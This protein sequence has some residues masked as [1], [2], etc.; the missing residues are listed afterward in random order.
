M[1]TLTKAMHS[2]KIEEGVALVTLNHPPV[3]ALTP[4]LLTELD[5][6]FD[7]LAMDEAV[8]IVV[9]T[10]AGRF[11][12]AGADIRVLASIPS[13]AEGEALARH[14]QTILNNIEDSEKP[15]IAAI[16]GACLGGGL[17]LAMC[18]HIRLAAESARLGQPEINL[19]I[20]PGFGGTQRLCRLI[21]Q[22]KAM[23]LILTGE[24]ISAREAMS[25]G[26]VSQ[27][28][29]AD[30]LLRQAQGLARKMAGKSQPALRAS[31]R[32]IRQGTKHDLSD[33]L[34]LEARLFGALCDT[35]DRKEGVAAF[36]EKR[37][38]LFRNR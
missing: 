30:D 33:G 25:L 14:G 28:V 12:V 17:E 23:E 21:G 10:G 37:Q 32:A 22:S 26:L 11:F 8:R 27:V 4:Q 9:L 18:C 20:M 1:A 5:S 19:G 24:P 15:V 3:N 7:S 31:L 6:T 13:S 38:P 34:A 29:S 2:C 36:L 16:N 35:D